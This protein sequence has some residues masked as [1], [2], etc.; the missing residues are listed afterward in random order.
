D[1]FNCQ[2][3]CDDTSSELQRV[4]ALEP[5]D[6][7][8]R[9][10]FR[11]RG[12]LSRFRIYT[13]MSLIEEEERPNSFLE[14]FRGPEVPAPPSRRSNNQPD[15]NGNTKGNTKQNKSVKVNY[16]TD[17]CCFTGTFI[18]SP[19]ND[20]YYYW[21]LFIAAAVLY[22]WVLLVARSCFDQM[23]TENLIIW[24]VFDY[25]CDAVYILDS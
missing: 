12:A 2:S 18:V 5:Q 4:A 13:N 22:N 20:I 7:L 21:L 23:Q 10:S 25:L 3:A 16:V 6:A 15:A 8:S 1:I 19:S 14:R 11:G 17:L 9:N 24:L